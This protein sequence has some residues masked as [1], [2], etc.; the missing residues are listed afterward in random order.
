MDRKRAQVMPEACT[1]RSAGLA[2]AL[3]VDHAL[4]AKHAGTNVGKMRWQRCQISLINEIN[5]SESG[6]GV[7]RNC[8]DAHLQQFP[9]VAN[10]REIVVPPS[11]VIGVDYLALSILY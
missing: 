6:L 7:G 3:P 4:T 11:G 8:A 9:F 2:I 10:E 5:I 1:Q